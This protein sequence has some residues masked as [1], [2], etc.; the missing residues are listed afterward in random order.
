MM[1]KDRGLGYSVWTRVPNSD[2]GSQHLRRLVLVDD[3]D[4]VLNL[5]SVRSVLLLIWLSAS[6]ICYGTTFTNIVML[7][8]HFGSLS[9]V[10]QPFVPSGHLSLRPVRRGS[11]FLLSQHYLHMLEDN[12]F[13]HRKNQNDFGLQPPGCCLCPR[14]APHSLV[15]IGRIALAPS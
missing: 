10:V 11:C 6:C 3:D 12:L 15:Q 7:R 9:K 4:G 14:R 2:S 8:S 1:D 5:H 13:T